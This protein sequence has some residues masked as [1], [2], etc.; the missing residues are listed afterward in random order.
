[1][2]NEIIKVKNDERFIYEK[3]DQITFSK[4]VSEDE[5]NKSINL[6]F[7]HF[8]ENGIVKD[9][10]IVCSGCGR[11]FIDSKFPDIN[12][13]IGLIEYNQCINRMNTNM[14]IHIKNEIDLELFKIRN[15]IEL[16]VR[17]KYPMFKPRTVEECPTSSEII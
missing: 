8:D 13:P 14:E 15:E 6:K 5:F 3:D 17:E 11:G 10:C 9:L 2:E 16:K 1:M 12:N 7:H 4:Y